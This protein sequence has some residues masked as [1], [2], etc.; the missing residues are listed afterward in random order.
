MGKGKTSQKKG[1]KGGKGKGKVTA[2]V[3]NLK[4][5]TGDLP[6]DRVNILLFGF[7]NDYNTPVL[8][9]DSCPREDTGDSSSSTNINIVQKKRHMAPQTKHFSHLLEERAASPVVSPRYGLR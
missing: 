5:V 3:N 9:E 7:P 8:D 4:K 2:I 6:Q 1:K